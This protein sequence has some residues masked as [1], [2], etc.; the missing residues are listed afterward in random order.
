MEEEEYFWPEPGDQL[1]QLGLGKHVAC[2]G[3]RKGDWYPYIQG[4]K[5]AADTLVAHLVDQN[6]YEVDFLVFPIAFLYRQCIELQ[7]KVVI[8]DGNDFLDKPYTMKPTHKLD[9]LW[10]QCREII[11]AIWPEENPSETLDAVEELLKEFSK[12]DPTSTAFRYPVKN[13]G[14]PEL[15]AIEHIDIEHLARNAAKIYN[16]LNASNTAIQRMADEKLEMESY[17]DLY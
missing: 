5:R 15:S 12:A 6:R 7:L 11:Q 2:V 3:F 13:N 9:V 1:F 8:N 10:T 17:Y 16:L 4:Y 14:N